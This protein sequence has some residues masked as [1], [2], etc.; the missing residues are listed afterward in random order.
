[1]LSRISS[2]AGRAQRAA[3]P[4]RRLLSVDA[5]SFKG[6]SLDNLFE[7]SPQELRALLDISHGLKKKL[8]ANPSSY[9]PLVRH[10]GPAGP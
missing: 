6:R 7:L 9:R 3:A 10:A 5:S 4:G 8:Q 2:A 1:M